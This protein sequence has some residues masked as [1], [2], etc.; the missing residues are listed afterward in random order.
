[1]ANIVSRDPFAGGIA[2]PQRSGDR[3]GQSLFDMVPAFFRPILEDLGS[4]GPK[5]DVKE[6]D[7]RYLVLL[8]VPGLDRNDIKVIV[9]QDT[10]T[11][12][13]QARQEQ[14]DAKESKWL[15]R[16]R[17]GSFTRT[18]TLPDEVDDEAATARFDNGVLY[19]TLP[20]KQAT[21]KKQIT[22]N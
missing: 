8:D 14:Q 12:E 3:M 1:M 18:I 11:V 5:M 9:E 19:L 22:I 2:S 17:L 16:E 21:N 20:K 15:L 10:V 6:T 7:D 4:N 13:A